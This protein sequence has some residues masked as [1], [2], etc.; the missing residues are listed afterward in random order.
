[1]TLMLGPNGKI[2]ARL[3]EIPYPNEGSSLVEVA[4]ALPLLL[5]GPALIAP[6]TRAAAAGV[7][8]TGADGVRVVGHQ[9]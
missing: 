4:L 9:R 5:L 6:P 8:A 3:R 2:W 1:M 7:P